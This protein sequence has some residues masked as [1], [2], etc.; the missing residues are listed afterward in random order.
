MGITRLTILICKL[1]YDGYNTH[2]WL[3]HK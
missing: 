1:E 2:L 3:G